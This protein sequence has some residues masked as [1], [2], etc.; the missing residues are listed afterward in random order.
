MI[1]LHQDRHIRFINLRNRFD[2]AVHTARLTPGRTNV[3]IYVQT[4]RNRLHQCAPRAGRRLKGS[5]LQQRHR[6]A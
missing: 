2:T 4:V 6:A 3:Q 1:T 5:T